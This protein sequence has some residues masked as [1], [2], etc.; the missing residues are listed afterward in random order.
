MGR[1]GEGARGRW[2]DAGG[3]TQGEART[4]RG[5]VRAPRDPLAVNLVDPTV[6]ATWH[7]A[8][9]Q[10]LD[11]A[12]LD[13]VGV[14]LLVVDARAEAEAEHLPRPDGALRLG[15][16]D[17]PLHP[18]VAVG[19]LPRR[20]DAPDG[21]TLVLDEYGRLVLVSAALAKVARGD[22][23]VRQVGGVLSRAVRRRVRDAAEAEGHGSPS[24]HR[25]AHVPP[26]IVLSETRGRAT[27]ATRAG[28]LVFFS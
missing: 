5:L 27:R 8:D 11:G 13:A 6:L 18:Q 2:G 1:G 7:L 10:L 23:G 17:R 20:K 9:T 21:T 15:V 26:Y 4:F 3:G 22:L 12:H 19:A 14:P 28:S 25:D 24:A 16:V